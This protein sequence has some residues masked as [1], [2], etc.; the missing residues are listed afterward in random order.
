MQGE[1][2]VLQDSTRMID[3]HAAG[4]LITLRPARHFCQGTIDG[5][6]AF[7]GQSLADI[8]L[9]EFGNSLEFCKLDVADIIP[10]VDE[11]V[12]PQWKRLQA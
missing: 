3:H 4:Q 9:G 2:R 7:F 1:S 5:L 12:H 6:T 8:V 11:F 10:Q